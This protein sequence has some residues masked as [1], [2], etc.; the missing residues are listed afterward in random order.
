MPPNFKVFLP[1]S[2]MPP[3]PG[4]VWSHVEKLTIKGS[5]NV[6]AKCKGCKHQATTNPAWWW[7]HLAVC[8][9]VTASVQ[10]QAQAEV[11]KVAKKKDSKH[12]AE[13][14]RAA[15][16]GSSHQASITSEGKGGMKRASALAADQAVA[17]FFLANGL[18]LRVADDHYFKAMLKAVKTADGS[19]KSPHRQRLSTDLL[20]RTKKRVKV[21]QE[22]VLQIG[23]QLNGATIVSDGWTDL[24]RRP[25]INVV[26]VTTNGEFFI[27][28]V[29]TSGD[30]KSMEYIADML[31]KHITKDIDFVV[32]D[33]ACKGAIEKLM[34]QFEWLSGVVCSTHGLELFMKDIGKQDFAADV[35]AGVKSAVKFINS[36]H[37][38]KAM[39]TKL[40][41][42]KGLLSPA[43]TR[44]SYHFIMIE[45]FVQCE[46]ALRSLV[47]SREY[48]DWSEAG[49]ADLR[50][51]AK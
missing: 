49:T 48:E 29:D 19:Y 38:T 30:K 42:N 8:A 40:S 28:A 41:P 24:N 7:E 16:T 51:E 10:K 15:A 39:F 25:L 17:D 9:K 5:G 26:L 13:L 32:M 35:L 2:T 43:A 6:L 31:S 47:A 33:G 14:L 50:D 36:H 22:A 1:L 34:E 46:D 20:A 23:M 18:P 11:D 44:F 3:Q 37:K 27:E 12:Q 4:A 45:R 21:D